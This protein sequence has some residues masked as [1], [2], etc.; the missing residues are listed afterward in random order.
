M[1]KLN[2][3]VMNNPAIFFNVYEYLRHLQRNNL[4]HPYSMTKVSLSWLE[5]YSADL[6]PMIFCKQPVN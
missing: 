6:R 1:L 3:I 2:T 5:S 4:S